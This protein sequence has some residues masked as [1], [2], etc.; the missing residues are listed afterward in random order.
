MSTV[1]QVYNLLQP[2]QSEAVIE[3]MDVQTQSGGNDCGL[4]AI[5]FAVA[6]CNGT[7][8]CDSTFTQSLMRSHLSGCLQNHT[9]CSF[10]SKPRQTPKE[11]KSIQHFPVFVCAVCQKTKKEWLSVCPVRSGF[12]RSVR[13]FLMQ[14][15]PRKLL[16]IVALVY[17]NVLHFFTVLCVF[18]FFA[19]L[20]GTMNTSVSTTMKFI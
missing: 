20:F 8:P 18:Y 14:F 17:C 4:F 6:L 11:P 16:G 1:C 9:I 5:A 3:M 12:I 13:R 15:L 19:V 2:C 7:S 10:S